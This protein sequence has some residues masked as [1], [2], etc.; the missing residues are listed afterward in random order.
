MNRK[1]LEELVIGDIIVW[2]DEGTSNFPS[3][4]ISA[5]IIFDIGEA[6]RGG[7]KIS[8][9]WSFFDPFYDEM[10]ASSEGGGNM[11]L[12]RNVSDMEGFIVL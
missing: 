2:V 5:V 7:S 6:V 3:K 8:R 9:V 1:N 12:E 11:V 4:V 10:H